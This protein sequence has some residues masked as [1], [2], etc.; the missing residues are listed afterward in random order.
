MDRNTVI[1]F[2]LLAILLFLYLFISSK[3]SQELGKQRKMYEDSMIK[4]NAKK[5]S[6]DTSSTDSLQNITVVKDTAGIKGALYGEEKLTTIENKL[7]KIIFTNK[8]GQPRSIELKNYLSY[9]STPV[10]L[11]S[12]ADRISYPVNTAINQ[13]A[14]ITDLYFISGPV[15]KNPDGSQT[16]T[17]QLSGPTGDMLTHQYIIQADN[18]AID[19]NVQANGK[20]KLFNQG[21]LN[22]NW[23]AQPMKH[24]Q[25]VVYERQLSNIG[26][27][28]DN[29]FDYISSRS[30]KSLKSQCIGW[31]FLN[32]FLI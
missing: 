18:Y 21:N 25:D 9:D 11:I 13:S 19:W 10:Q 6:I 29:E 17:Y 31:L 5:Q 28:E 22:I 15:V 27:Y 20:E 3:N 24:Q 12:E 23:H 2:V 1:G 8:G 30:E 14:Q 4:I 32:S 16:V 7:M 26:F